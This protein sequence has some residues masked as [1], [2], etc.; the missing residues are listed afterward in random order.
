MIGS[1][2]DSTVSSITTDQ[3]AYEA[4]D[5]VTV[6]VTAANIGNKAVSSAGVKLDI[7]GVGTQSKNVSSLAAGGGNRTVTF[8]FTAPTSLT[9]QTIT[10]TATADPD[11][12][13]REAT[14]AITPE[15]QHWV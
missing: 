5:T 14:K 4:G 15:L 3:A 13:I 9:A 12:A 7:S 11:N 1:L 10:L 2:P 8:T 6:T